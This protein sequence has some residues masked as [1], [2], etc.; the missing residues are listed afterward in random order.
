MTAEQKALTVLEKIWYLQHVGC[1]DHDWDAAW[2]EAEQVID[3]ARG[4]K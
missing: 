4:Q 2:A 1:A 3:E